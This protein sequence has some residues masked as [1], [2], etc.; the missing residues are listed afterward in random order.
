MQ[1]QRVVPP[2]MICKDKFL[3]QCAVVPVGMAEEDITSATVPLKD[4]KKYIEMCNL[5]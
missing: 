4:I 5:I 3:L 2:E 1:A